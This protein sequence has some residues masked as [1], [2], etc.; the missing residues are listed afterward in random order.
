MRILRCAQNDRTGRGLARRVVAPHKI[1][2]RR[3]G[4]AGGQRP[5]LR[6]RHLER[7]RRI[8]LSRLFTGP[9]GA[10][11]RI[12]RLRLR[13]TGKR[14]GCVPERKTRLCLLKRQRR[15]DL[16]GTTLVAR[17]GRTT[18]RPITGPAVPAYCDFSGPLQ[19]DPPVPSSSAS[20]QYGGSLCGDGGGTCPFPRVFHMRTV[21]YPFPGRL[22]SPGFTRRSAGPGCPPPGR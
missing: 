9:H 5:P 6:S 1:K 21:S 8:R 16:C 11:K 15:V 4:T 17:A 10:G 14:G 20:H 12:L 22:S 2:R 18:L 19:G 3:I 7:Q 13:M